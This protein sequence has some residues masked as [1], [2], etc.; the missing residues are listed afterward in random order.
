MEEKDDIVMLF[1]EEGNEIPFEHLDT[2]ELNDNVYV[3]LLEVIEGEPEDNDE[4]VILRLDKDE[5]G[6]DTLSI[7]E[8]ED[9]LNE[10][11][12]EFSN[13]VEDQFEVED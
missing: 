9:E 12:E 11:F 2:F 8:D 7:V 5:S 6:E 4:V 3:V 1:D 13:R 10:A